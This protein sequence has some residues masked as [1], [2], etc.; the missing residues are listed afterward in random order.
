MWSGR[1]RQLVVT[2]ISIVDVDRHDLD[3]AAL[4]QPWEQ[5]RPLARTE[6]EDAWEAA[7]FTFPSPYVEVPSPMRAYAEVSFPAGRADRRRRR[8]T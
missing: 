8:S 5:G 6:V 1:T 3:P 7:D 4:G 2:A